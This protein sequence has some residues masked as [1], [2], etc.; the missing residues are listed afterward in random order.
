[1]HACSLAWD[2]HLQHL[3]CACLAVRA[4]MPCVQMLCFCFNAHA[5][6]CVRQPRHAQVEQL[7]RDKAALEAKKQAQ[8]KQM[9]EVGALPEDRQLL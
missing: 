2:L 6:L 4:C 3:C 9:E 7:Q 5:R 8:A 1:M